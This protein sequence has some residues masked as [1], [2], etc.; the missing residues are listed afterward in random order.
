LKTCIAFTVD[1]GSTQGSGVAERTH[2]VTE[3]TI[4]YGYFTW[5][6]WAIG[7]EKF[8]LFGLLS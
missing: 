4:F 6:K 5:D 3:M 8:S 2:L 7:M 1:I